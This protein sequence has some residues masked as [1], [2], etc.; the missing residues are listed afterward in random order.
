ML[1]T[2]VQDRR[3]LH[4]IPEIGYNLPKTRAY[5]KS[6]VLPLQPDEMR[7][8]AGGLIFIFR[9]PSPAKDCIAFRADMDALEIQENTGLDF[10]SEHPGCMHAC[11]HDGHMANLL[12]LARIVVNR[13]QAGT[14][15]RDVVF[16][17]QPAEESVGGALKMIQA[18]AFAELTISEIYGMHVMPQ[19]PKERIGICEGAQMAMVVCMDISIR[20]V[21]GHGAQPHNACDAVFAMAHFISNVQTLIKHRINTFDPSILSIG[22]VRAGDARNIVSDW[23]YLECTT[24][25]FSPKVSAEITEM[26]RNC[27]QATD[28]MFGTTSEII[29]STEY[30][31]VINSPKETQKVIRLA[32]KR[33]LPVEAMT[34]AEDFSEY[35]KIMPGAFFFTG[36]GDETHSAPLHSSKFDFDES[37]L[38]PALELFT[39][40]L[41]D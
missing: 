25:A 12:C 10:A 24:R 35:Q 41:D 27:L 15:D 33:Y 14:L 5:I 13:K 1:S 9:A 31:A 36:T 17:F 22:K 11:G 38:L 32:G 3:A 6:I 30:P 7:E 34:I 26:I 39:A 20:G 2:L 28:L 37:A 23:A 8:V 18:G 16:V 4:R 29:P 21:S 40:L 19:F